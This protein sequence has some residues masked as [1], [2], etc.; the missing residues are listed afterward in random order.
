MYEVVCWNFHSTWKLNSY[1]CYK[2]NYLCWWGRWILDTHLLRNPNSKVLGAASGRGFDLPVCL[3]FV[4]FVLVTLIIIGDL[5]SGNNVGIRTN[6][7][8]GLVISCLRSQEE[9]W[10]LGPMQV[11]M[12]LSKSIKCNWAFCELFKKLWHDSVTSALIVLYLY[13][14]TAHC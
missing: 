8:W 6:L 4:C 14:I 2:L 3:Y 13:L 1:D 12:S 5:F 11:N 7:G 9:L 10:T